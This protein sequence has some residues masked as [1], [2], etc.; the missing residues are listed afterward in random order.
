M[1]SDE[2]SGAGSAGCLP[3]GPR[4][5]LV[6]P[7]RV[8]EKA[9]QVGPMQNKAATYAIAITGVAVVLLAYLFPQVLATFKADPT[10][11]GIWFFLLMVAGIITYVALKGGGAVTGTA[12]VN[13]AVIITYGGP[14]AAWLAAVEMLILTRMLLNFSSLRS[15]FNMSQMAVSLLLAGFVY[16]AAGGTRLALTNW[17]IRM[18]LSS[19]VPLALCHLTYFFSNTILVTIWSSLRVGRS[20]LR[21]WKANYLWMMPQ[22][23]AA[24]VVGVLLAYVYVRLSPWLLGV[25]FLWLLYYARTSRTNLELQDSQRGTVAALATTVD[26]STPFLEG[27][28][29]RVAS[30]AVELGRRIGLSGWRMQALEYAALL[31]DIGYL[32]V[33]KRV[34]AK[35]ESLS[36]DE[37]ATVRKHA[38]VGA[39]IIGSVRALRRVSDIVRAHHERPDGKGYPKGLSGEAIPKEARILKVADAFVAMT[40]HRPYRRALTIGD[41][42]RKIRTGAGSHFD[43]QTVRGLL[44]LQALSILEQYGTPADRAA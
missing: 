15:L 41:A 13:F 32:S 31:H 5:T 11:I 38:E 34:L 44:D 8:S 43:T 10:G 18:S 6:H 1:R 7:A 40:S 3:A 35:G 27:E 19:L 28:S 23:F 24:P 14:V 12:V 4:P 22:S 16:Q 39:L 36:P 29:E 37:W 25:F 20:A 33:G 30:L 21:T 26:S 9:K 2:Q 17:D 42:I